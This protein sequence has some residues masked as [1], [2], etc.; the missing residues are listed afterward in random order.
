MNE[1]ASL[2]TPLPLAPERLEDLLNRI[3]RTR[4]AVIGDFCL[5]IY[6]MIDPARSE[7]SLETGRMTQ[8]VREQRFSLGGAGNVIANLAA[9]GC[10]HIH[11]LGVVGDDPWGRE[12]RRLLETL[13]VEVSGLQ[14]QAEGWSTLAYNKPYVG[15]E[16]QPRFDFGGFQTLPETAAAKLLADCR[17]CAGAVEVVIVNQQVAAGIH[18][19]S[20]RAGLAALI[21]DFPQTLFIADSRHFTDAYAGAL[22]KINEHEAARICC[23]ARGADELILREEACGAAEELYRRQRKPLVLTRGRRGLLVRDDGGLQEI[24]GIQILGPVDTVGAGDSLL[25]GLALGLAA[26]GS[27]VEAAQLGNFTAGV[28][29]QKL[30]Q[31]GTATPDEIRAIGRDCDYIYRPELAEDPRRIRRV[32]GTEFEVVTRLP[33]GRGITGAIFDHDGTL[34]TLRQGWEAVMEPMM[35]RAVLGPAYAT[36]DESRYHRV[37]A[38]VRRFIDETCGIQTLVQMQGLVAM[39]REFGHVPESEIQDAPAYKQIYNEALMIM[40]RERLAKFK[41][42]ELAAADFMI[43]NAAPFLERL[44]GAGVRLYLASGTDQEDVEAEARALGYA[45][46]FTGGIHG[47][48]GDVTREAKRIVLERLLGEIG[49]EGMSGVVVF[50]DGP[51]ELRESCKRGGYAI[52]LATDE[53]RRYGLNPAKR[54]RLIKAGADLIIPDY[55][56]MEA[57]LKLL[58]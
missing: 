2:S 53:V 20:V 54:T 55:S 45:D 38:R 42:G 37:V 29:V 44:A 33:A 26:G 51:V 22:L 47:A 12:Q 34:S 49:S 39:V 1:I 58:G 56:Q 57:L 35:V 36:A 46:F 18:S 16:E 31:T 17:R 25:A 28:T 30:R 15:D 40:V 23:L 11:A 5:D 50:G 52:G 3:S 13:G 43:K 7:P 10:R 4:V 32:E 8:P 19:P 6:W 48:T 41:R 9:L 24:P 21:R 27:L 14:V